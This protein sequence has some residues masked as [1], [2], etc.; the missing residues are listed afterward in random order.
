MPPVEEVKN[1]KGNLSSVGETLRIMASTSGSNLQTMA[2][3]ADY[4]GLNV[5]NVEWRDN[6][7]GF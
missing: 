3:G 5:R 2:L 4:G 6:D 7:L 1:D